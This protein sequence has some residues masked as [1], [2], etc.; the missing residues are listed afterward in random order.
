M[1]TEEK[2]L[3][4]LEKNCADALESGILPISIIAYAAKQRGR[5]RISFALFVRN[6]RLNF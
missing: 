4:I 2:M 1:K 6:M 3:H 5:M